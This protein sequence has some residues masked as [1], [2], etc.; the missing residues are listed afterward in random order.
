MSLIEPTPTQAVA[1]QGHGNDDVVMDLERTGLGE[2]VGQEWGERYVALILVIVEDARQ[3]SSVI[4]LSALIDEA[5]AC[6]I[7]AAP[8]AA[9]GG[10]IVITSLAAER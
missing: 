4:M 6:A 3:R 7:E 2:K 10:T 8:A 5:C 1:M 9:A